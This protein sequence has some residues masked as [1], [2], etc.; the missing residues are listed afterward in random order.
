MDRYVMSTLE[1]ALVPLFI[2]PYI[3]DPHVA[4]PLSGQLTEG[5]QAKPVRPGFGSGNGR[6]NWQVEADMSKEAS[7]MG[8]LGII[9]GDQGERSS[10]GHRPPNVGGKRTIY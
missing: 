4:G 7:R 2:P 3:D 5:R 6:S 10:P 9:G 1:V 8:Q